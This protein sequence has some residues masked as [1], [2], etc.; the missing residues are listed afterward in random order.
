MIIIG[1]MSGTSLDGLDLA[2][3]RFHETDGHLHYEVLAADTVPYEAGWQVA[4]AQVMRGTALQ[5]AE[6]DASF[7]RFVGQQV[8]IFMDQRGL[9]A[10]LVASHGHTIFHQP[11]SGFTTQIGNG[12]Y[13]AASAGLPAITD[14]RTADV[15][16]GGEGA[17]L[18][19][20]GDQLLFAQYPFCL[21]LGGI[22]NIS[23]QQGGRRLAFDICAVN[24]VLNFLAQQLGHDYDAGG[25]LAAM[26]HV[27]SL[28]LQALDAQP[29]FHQPAPKSL[30]K[31][32]VEQLYF[33]HLAGAHHLSLH[34]QLATVTEHAA[35]QMARVLER[36]GEAGKVL[37]TG[38]GAFNTHLIYRLR[39]LAGPDYEIVVPDALTVQFK[40]AIIFAL[41]GYL[42]WHNRPN[43]LA[44]VT[45]AAKDACGGALY[46]P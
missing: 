30:G 17:P 1:C 28:L 2:A 42:R 27:D 44:T 5:L 13:V 6:M 16:F 43:S 46:M 23:F 45:G 35:G 9:R 21:N 26:G 39:E 7:G 36:S 11:H 40:E 32:A 33:H 10:D 8:R 34:D 4:L 25:A 14:F 19:P 15:A 31:E 38:G 29:Y 3:V 37:V 18:V 20:L 41:L 24:M 22:A 12:A